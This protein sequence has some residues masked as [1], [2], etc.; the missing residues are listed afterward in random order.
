MDRRLYKGAL[1]YL[2]HWKGYSV[3]D[4]TWEP[5][6]NLCTPRVQAEMRAYDADYPLDEERELA[7][8]DEESD[9]EESDEEESDDEESDE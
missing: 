1:Q 8:D 4:S 2:V 7:S 3:R 5:I 9:D 6:E